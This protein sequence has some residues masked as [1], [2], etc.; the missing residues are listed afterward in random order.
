MNELALSE[1]DQVLR[2]RF[3][4]LL[5]Y[6]GPAAPGGV[7]HAFK[8]LERALPLLAENGTPPP[9]REL[10][11][12]TAFPGPGAR[13]AFEMAT[14][15]VSEGRYQVDIAHPDAGDALPSPRGCYFFRVRCGTR[16]V[17]C[18]IRPGLVHQAFLDLSRKADRSAEE[19]S[20]LTTLKWEMTERLLAHPA[21]AVY[22]ATVSAD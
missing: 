12:E 11:I 17:D 6:H 13:D 14:R 16:R 2:Y 19:E 20:H 1:A 18:R 8:V 10:L 5:L 3:E 21:E 4:D 7:A 22:D 15:C 9:R